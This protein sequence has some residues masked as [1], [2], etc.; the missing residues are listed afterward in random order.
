MRERV[1]EAGGSRSERVKRGRGT[2]EWDGEVKGVIVTSDSG[3]GME[4]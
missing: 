2:G 3:G 1:P 4:G